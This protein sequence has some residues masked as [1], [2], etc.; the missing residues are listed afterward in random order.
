MAFLRVMAPAG[1][2]LRAEPSTSA[3]RLA[4]LPLGASVEWIATVSGDP[5][6]T[7][8]GPA[9]SDWQQVRAGAM[10]G[11]VAAVWLEAAGLQ[12]LRGVWI[13]SHHHSGVWQSRDTVAR[14][15]DQ[16]VALG[17]NTIF[18]AVWNQGFTAWPSAVMERLGLPRQDPVVA[19]TGVDPLQL[20]V[21]LGHERGLTVIPWL[22]YGFAAE[23]VGAPRALLA[24]RPNWAARDRK[25]NVV[26]DGGLRWLNG[27]D[28]EVQAF[29]EA[30]FLEVVERYGVDGVQGDDHLAIPLI[31][32]HDSGTLERY[33]QATGRAP[34]RR[35]D[36]PQWSRYRIGELSR[37]VRHMG[38]RIHG[39]RPD[40]LWCLS[41]CPLPTGLTKLMQDSTAWLQEGAVD[42]LLPQLYRD[43]LAGFRQVLEGNLRPL[44]VERRQRLVAG[45][46]LRANGV[47]L[48][49]DTLVQMVQLCRE[50]G[51]GGISLFHHT[52]LMGSDQQIARALQ[53]KGGLNQVA[54][55][56]SLAAPA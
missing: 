56:P 25:G 43:N 37:W 22:E 7:P 53:E 27:L 32:S 48:P 38:E 47:D 15:L 51:L 17:W 19:Q 30:L 41:P 28:P 16:L 39:I 31:G 14:A 5:Y 26:E 6:D 12:E 13:C 50:Q 11:F 42:L 8:G 10:E 18:P 44:A 33:R 40:L 54:V 20:A 29:L 34:G 55:L 21:E 23:A 1:V 2:A 4:L 45:L 35:D 9:R 36:D 49:A 46:T 24:A 3:R 52:P